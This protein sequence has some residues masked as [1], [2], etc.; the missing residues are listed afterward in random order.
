MDSKEQIQDN[1]AGLEHKLLDMCRATCNNQISSNV[2]YIVLDASSDTAD[3][4]NRIYDNYISG[5]LISREQV[6]NHV[7]EMQ[8]SLS[9]VDFQLYCTS[10]TET[11]VVAV[12]VHKT[13]N[14]ESD[15]LNYH[16]SILMPPGIKTEDEKFDANWLMKCQRD[17]DF[18]HGCRN[19]IDKISKYFSGKKRF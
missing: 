4:R 18:K 9:W 8:D 10:E 16:A 5:N 12:L 11:V 19:L 13:G 17:A 2:K 7:Y 3:F 15:E 6:I 1:L 14:A